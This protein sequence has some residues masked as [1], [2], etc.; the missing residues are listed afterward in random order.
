MFQLLGG[1]KN[2]FT[3]RSAKHT[4][5][6]YIYQHL[7]M[8]VSPRITSREST[9]LLDTPGWTYVMWRLY[10]S[11]HNWHNN[12][13]FPCTNM[14]TKLLFHASSFALSPFVATNFLLL[15]CSWKPSTS[16]RSCHYRP[17]TSITGRMKISQHVFLDPISGRWEWCSK[18][19][20]LM[21]IMQNTQFWQSVKFLMW[22][23]LSSW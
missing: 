21:K 9:I 16:V 18:N 4:L 13:L 3:W 15:L 17:G 8:D 12:G 11:F 10:S 5:N 6:I 23:S 20:E 2:F 19:R 14:S 7:N 1:R 22:K